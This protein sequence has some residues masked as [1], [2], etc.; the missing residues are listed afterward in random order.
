VKSFTLSTKWLRANGKLAL[1]LGQRPNWLL[2]LHEK[3]L[4]KSQKRF[5]F[6]TE[7]LLAQIKEASARN[8]AALFDRL[9]HQMG[10]SFGAI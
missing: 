3:R 4:S 1:G 5:G 2:A 7:K 10:T 9:V 6:W 8:W